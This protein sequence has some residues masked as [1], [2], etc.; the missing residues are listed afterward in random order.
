MKEDELSPTVIQKINELAEKRR[1]IALLPPEKALTEIFNA[2]VPEALVQ[3]FPK[4]DFYFLVKQMGYDD[5]M[6]LFAM[7]SNGQWEFLM[8]MDVW[9]K[10]VLDEKEVGKTFARLLDADPKRLVKW[11]TSDEKEVFEL[12]LYRTVDVRIREHD[13][14]PSDFGDDF[15][16]F[17]D[18]MYFKV[19][20]DPATDPDRKEAEDVEKFLWTL[21]STILEEDMESLRNYVWEAKFI[22]S[23]EEEEEAYCMRN[24]R[25]AESGFAPFDEA[26]GVYQPIWPNEFEKKAVRKGKEKISQEDSLL[27][28]PQFFTGLFS[29]TQLFVKALAQIQDANVWRELQVE[30][31]A[32]SNRLI[33]ADEITIEDRADLT[34]VVKKA[35]GYLDIGLDA[36]IKEMPGRTPVSV[37]EDFALVDIFRAGYSFVLKSK[38]DADAFYKESKYPLTFWGEEK[39]G[40]LGGLLLPRPLLY[41]ENKTTENRYRDFWN[42]DDI[43]FARHELEATKAL[44]TVF[45]QMNLP[46]AGAPKWV[47]WSTLLMTYFANDLIEKKEGALPLSEKEVRWAQGKL[48]RKKTETEWA[49]NDD[50]PSALQA[51]MEKNNGT[52]TPLVEESL[53]QMWREIEEGS[54]YVNPDTVSAKYVPYFISEE[55]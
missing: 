24:V 6:D 2:P 55:I 43:R 44:K 13:Q 39:M 28:V 9:K 32:V 52:I 11:V 33:V 34:K 1:E 15:F 23:A 18:V 19:Y 7:A 38:W 20:A 29:D 35:V 4:E 45:D 40:M 30:F 12:Y 17:D 48:F 42:T 14:D 31:A 27:P 25:L 8:D 51:W 54:K 47:A 10:D 50:M 46:M 37:L 22:L 16:T 53:T 5:A 49:L 41:D 3:S 26:I 21:F 36:V